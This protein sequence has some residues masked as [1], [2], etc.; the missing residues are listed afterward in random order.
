M[1]EAEGGMICRPEGGHPAFKVR[2][3]KT[4]NVERSVA[5][6]DVDLLAS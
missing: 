2:C 1:I 3:V 4:S 6:V 5:R